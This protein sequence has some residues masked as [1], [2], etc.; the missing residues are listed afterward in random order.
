MSS[1]INYTSIDETYPIAGTN[2]NTQ[3]FRDNFTAIKN[4]LAEASAE[5]STLQIEITNISGGVGS[6][7]ASATTIASSSTI[8]PTNSITFISGT[9]AIDTIT[10]PSPISLG[11]GYITLIP[12]A[13]FTTTTAGNIA[14]AST[15]VAYKAL[16]MF[17][18]AGTTKW[19]PSY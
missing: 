2:N 19:Y 6:A 16:T 1:N 4:G 14:L 10:V 18:D 8:A 17:Y 12:T 9:N 11:G 15:A 5:I 7:G 13:A 3:G